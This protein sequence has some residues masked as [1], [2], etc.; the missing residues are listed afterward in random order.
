MSV[1]LS[2][3]CLQEGVTVRVRTSLRTGTLLW[4]DDPSPQRL[5]FWICE[6]GSGLEGSLPFGHSLSV[7]PGPLRWAGA[8]SDEGIRQEW[9]PFRGLGEMLLWR[10]GQAGLGRA[11]IG[12]KGRLTWALVRGLLSPAP[13]LGLT[14]LLLQPLAPALALALLLFMGPGWGG[15][16]GSTSSPPRCTDRLGGRRGEGQGHCLGGSHRTREEGGLRGAQR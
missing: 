8:C 4:L 16:A 15:G 6:G 11:G 10:L 12:R 7:L 9:T 14:P 1:F 3:V 5:P 2:C 13:A